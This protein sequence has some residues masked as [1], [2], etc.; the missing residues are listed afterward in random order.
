MVV[1]CCSVRSGEILVA[2]ATLGSLV[3]AVIWQRVVRSSFHPCTLHSGLR[4][5][6]V[7]RKVSLVL[8]RCSRV[9]SEP[10][11]LQCGPLW[12]RMVVSER[13]S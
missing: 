7:T 5:H 9:T 13:V 2:V 6:V 10:V 12:W 11:L 4:A 3:M 1:G 8:C